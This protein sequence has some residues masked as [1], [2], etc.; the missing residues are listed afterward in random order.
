MA[1]MSY[2]KF[3]NT[4]ADLRDCAEELANPGSMDGPMSDTEKDAK[5]S[6]VEL[7]CDIAANERGME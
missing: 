6:L 5:K 1:N 7:C 4:L 2:C 3:E